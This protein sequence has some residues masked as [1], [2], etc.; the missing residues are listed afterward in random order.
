MRRIVG[1]RSKVKGSYKTT[2][3]WDL[4]KIINENNK[5]NSPTALNIERI[6]EDIK[7]I[8]MKMTPFADRT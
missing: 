3:G 5:T 2:C 8:I 1:Q 6:V 4:Q 7:I